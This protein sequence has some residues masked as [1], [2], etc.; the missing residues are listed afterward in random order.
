MSLFRQ[1]ARA[2]Q[3]PASNFT[4]PWVPLPGMHRPPLGG[5]AAMLKAAKRGWKRGLQTRAIT[6]V[7]KGVSK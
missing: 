2:E 1:Y 7:L 4:T 6:S 3:P 5:K